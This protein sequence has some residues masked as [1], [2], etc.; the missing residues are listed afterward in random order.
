MLI[1]T[2]KKYQKV[3]KNASRLYHIFARSHYLQQLFKLSYNYLT[4]LIAYQPSRKLGLSAVAETG[5]SKVRLVEVPNTHG[6]DIYGA[7]NIFDN[8]RIVYRFDYRFVE[9]FNGSRLRFKE[10]P[11]KTV[12]IIEEPGKENDRSSLDDLRNI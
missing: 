2:E 10:K 7:K 1:R 6:V 8:L 11:P 5:I 4:K 9:V 3:R 12:G